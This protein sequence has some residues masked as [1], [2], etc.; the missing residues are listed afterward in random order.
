MTCRWMTHNDEWY[1]DGHAISRQNYDGGVDDGVDM[2][3]S[4]AVPSVVRGSVLSALLALGP[5]PGASSSS[6]SSSAMISARM[7]SNTEH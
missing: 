1:A 2:A 6:S 3:D 5:G 4:E 7:V